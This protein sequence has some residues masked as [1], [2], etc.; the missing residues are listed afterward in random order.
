VEFS[1][2]YGIRLKL[3]KEQNDRL[4]VVCPKLENWVIE[5]AKASSIKMSGKD[6]SLSEKP[7]ELHAYI[8]YRVANF[9]RPAA[10]LP[11]QQSP[12]PGRLRMLVSGKNV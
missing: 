8:N 9:E 11:R 5:T 12:R 7:G 6:H 3:D 10:H 4:I 2:E 1:A